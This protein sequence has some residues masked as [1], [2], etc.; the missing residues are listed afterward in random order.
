MLSASALLAVPAPRLTW[1]AQVTATLVAHTAS[2][3]SARF[4]DVMP[5]VATASVDGTALVWDI[6]ARAHV[7]AA[8]RVSCVRADA[9]PFP[10]PRACDSAAS[11]A[12]P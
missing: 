8:W 3:E 10:S 6:Q 1:A 2:V 9:C 11:M 5:Y 7:R 12:R 4:C